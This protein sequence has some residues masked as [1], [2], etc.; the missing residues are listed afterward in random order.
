[1]TTINQEQRGLT[2][3]QRQTLRQAAAARV[4]AQAQ[5][6]T[7]L[8]AI[9]PRFVGSGLRE[10]GPEFDQKIPTLSRKSEAAVQRP[11]KA[12]LRPPASTNDSPKSDGIS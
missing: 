10:S 1:M 4:R 12:S 3:P 6:R 9:S 7:H 5:A 2:H 11:V 8:A